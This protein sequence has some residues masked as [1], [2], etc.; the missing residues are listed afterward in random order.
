MPGKLTVGRIV[1]PED[2]QSILRNAQPEVDGIISKLNSLEYGQGVEVI[3]EVTIK[4]INPKIRYHARKNGFDIMLRKFKNNSGFTVYKKQIP[5]PKDPVTVDM[6]E[7]R[8]NDETF[9]SIG[10][11]YGITRQA[12][13]NRIKGYDKLSTLPINQRSI[14]LDEELKP[15]LDVLPENRHCMLCKREMGERY[16]DRRLNGMCK[17]CRDAIAIRE[18]LASRLRGLRKGKRWRAQA[19]WVIRNYGVMPEDMKDQ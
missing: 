18:N 16:K 11:S 17:G 8:L 12:V 1:S 2:V 19:L 7:R 13:E 14:A 15:F 6:I 3:T 4:E 10:A 5:E 9:D